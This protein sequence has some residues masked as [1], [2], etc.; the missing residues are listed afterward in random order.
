MFTYAFVQ[1]AFLAGIFIALS[2]AALGCFL[3]LRRFA[4]I[5][6][7][8]AHT[9][10]A[11]VALA[12]VAGASP[13]A[14]AIP[15]VMALSLGILKL[16]EKATLSGETAIGL[17]SSLAMATGVLLAGSGGGFNIDLYS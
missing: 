16:R 8:L 4:M 14:L 12:L 3:V 15:L 5:G 1:R 17:V 13:L 2:C 11:A 9:G 10:F 7:G 6:D